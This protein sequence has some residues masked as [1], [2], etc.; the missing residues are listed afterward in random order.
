M[1]ANE[2]DHKLFDS[3]N[4]EPI[5]DF[6]SENLTVKRSSSPYTDED[7]FANEFVSQNL[8]KGTNVLGD[9]SLSPIHIS[10]PTRP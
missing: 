9:I 5:N 1:P 8:P 6:Y 3:P 10:E 4:N 2:A 7:P